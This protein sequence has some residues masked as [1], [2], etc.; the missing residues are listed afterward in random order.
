MNNLSPF[1]ETH[2]EMD[3][4]L[5]ERGQTGIFNDSFLKKCIKDKR[6]THI[7]SK[8]DTKAATGMQIGAVS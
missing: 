2:I 1:F 6:N 4:L 7:T 8:G 3:G 5:Q